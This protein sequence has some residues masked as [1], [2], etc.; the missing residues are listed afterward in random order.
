MG[1][2]SIA[3]PIIGAEAIT[4]KE[5]VTTERKWKMQNILNYTSQQQSQSKGAAQLLIHS[6]VCRNG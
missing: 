2:V 4:V 3:Q 6:A 5:G 1:N